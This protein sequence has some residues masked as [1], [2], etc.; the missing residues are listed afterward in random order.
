[1]KTCNNIQEHT[2]KLKFIET[3]DVA[4]CVISI[5]SYRTDVS[6][7]LVE[8][9]EFPREVHGVGPNAS[10]PGGNVAL[11]PAGALADAS[12][13][14][15]IWAAGHLDQ[16][17]ESLRLGDHHR[18][19]GR[20]DDDLLLVTRGRNVHDVHD[21]FLGLWLHAYHGLHALG[22]RRE[23]RLFPRLFPQLFPQL[24][25]RLFK[26]LDTG[27]L[28]YWRWSRGRLSDDLCP[29]LYDVLL[30]L[31]AGLLRRLDDLQGLDRWGHLLGDV[32]GLLGQ[33]GGLH[34]AEGLHG[35]Q[36]WLEVVGLDLGGQ[37]GLRNQVQSLHRAGTALDLAILTVRADLHAEGGLLRPVLGV[38]SLFQLQVARPQ[39]ELVGHRLLLDLTRRDGL[40][41][42]QAQQHEGETGV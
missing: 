33:L 42:R 13:V 20:N 30:G 22:L 29:L 23:V 27:S 3:Y 8:A 10:S 36:G 35:L 12:L 18:R 31:W 38:A 16:L 25:P 28:G 19:L 4:L 21:F 34:H 9:L 17:G 1:M 32:D 6:H 11:V 14:G 26:F 41:R 39:G 24:F 40:H 15:M 37:R 7:L 5:Q 2:T